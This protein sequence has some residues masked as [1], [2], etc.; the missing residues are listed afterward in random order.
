MG[1]GDGTTCENDVTVFGRTVPGSE[2]DLYV[3]DVLAGT[4]AAGKQGRWELALTLAEGDHALKAVARR[5]GHSSPPSASMAITVDSA[6]SWSPL[7]LRFMDSRGRSIRPVDEEGRTDAT[8]W[9]IR[10][11]PNATY[12]VAVKLCCTLPGATVELIV[13]DTRTVTLT[14]ADGD[15]VYA[16]VFTSSHATHTGGSLVL[17]V[18]CGEDVVRNDG[19]VLIDPEG[20][21][22]DIKTLVPLNAASVA[23]QQGQSTPAG[24]GTATVFDLWPAADYGQ[25]NPL[26]TGG[27][28]YF[29]FFTPAGIYRLEVTR[30]GYQSYRS[31]DIVVVDAAVRHDLALT[32][33]V[34]ETAHHVVAVSEAGFEPAFLQVQ[35]GDVVE[36]V[37]MDAAGHTVTAD[38]VLTAASSR[39]R[40]DSGQLLPGESYRFRFDQ[41][42]TYTYADG[43]D[44]ANT[45][46]IQ[47]TE[48]EAVLSLRLFLPVVVR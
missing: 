2:V 37:N 44:L 4:T 31:T 1:P 17:V 18:Q 48:Q 3:D 35:M 15:Q 22:S 21:V 19:A 36:W 45:G 23:C 47:V 24:V 29:S 28:G 20:V 13:S 7:S 40:F 34:D 38:A 27:D 30:S 12:T 26:T 43:M 42:G 41:T 25:S 16:G 5:G 32:P 10:L 9:R 46:S 8:G 6:L 11:H 14:D 39:T 33:V